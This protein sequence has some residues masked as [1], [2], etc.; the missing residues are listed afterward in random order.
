[1]SQKRAS[2]KEGTWDLNFVRKTLKA[3]LYLCMMI[4]MHSLVCM[5][6]IKQYILV[7]AVLCKKKQTEFNHD[8]HFSKAVNRKRQAIRNLINILSKNRQSKDQPKVKLFIETI[9]KSND[10]QASMTLPNLCQE[11]KNLKLMFALMLGEMKCEHERS[12]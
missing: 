7:K 9:I 5:I 6:D 10:I 3:C 2:L 4:Q 11:E 8:K 12:L 1:M